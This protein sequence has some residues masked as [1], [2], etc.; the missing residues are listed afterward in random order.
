MGCILCRPKSLESPAELVGV[1]AKHPRIIHLTEKSCTGKLLA[2]VTELLARSFCGSRSTAPEGLSSHI[3]S[4]NNPG[5]GSCLME[6]PSPERLEFFRYIAKWCLAQALR[7]N[8]CF[9]LLDEKKE[10]IVAVTVTVLPNKRHL[11]S[12]GFFEHRRI[13]RAA[14]STPTILQRD[15]D[16]SRRFDELMKAF[17][18]SHH[19]HASGLHIYVWIV[20]VS[21]DHQGIGAGRLLM[22][23][24][25][26]L[27]DKLRVPAYL[28]T[29]GERNER[30]Y[31]RNRYE[32]KGHYV[33][34]NLDPGFAAM[35]RS[36]ISE[37]KTTTATTNRNDETS[38]S[39]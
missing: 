21:V 14:G 24:I 17:H 26:D 3:I 12:P 33:F 4:P 34:D 37:L 36:P 38:E 16:A 5:V 39:S 11:H 13:L 18:I 35:V 19:N 29:I 9:G 28:E 2:E 27:A 23:F 6:D 7:H 25:G 32:V 22:D 31:I 30:F 10:Q 20:A 15:P 1:L 8:G